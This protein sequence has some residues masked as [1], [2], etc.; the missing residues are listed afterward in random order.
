VVL[1]H[2]HG[3]EFEEV[4][5]TFEARGVVL[6]GVKGL[7][8]PIGGEKVFTMEQLKEIDRRV[9]EEIRLL[10]LRRKI[11]SAGRRPTVFLPEDVVRATGVK[12]GDE[13]DIYLEGKK[14]V[15]E[16]V[17]PEEVEAEE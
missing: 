5:T 7:M 17:E 4:E 11:S 12:V 8:C 3:V 16:P 9:S 14:I 10:R 13:I 1:C 15:I 2:E 6:H